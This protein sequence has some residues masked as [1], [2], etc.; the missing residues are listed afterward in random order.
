MYSGKPRKSPVCLKN[1][2]NVLE[3]LFILFTTTMKEQL[4]TLLV[5]DSEKS[6]PDNS[7]ILILTRFWSGFF[8]DHM[9][10]SWFLEGDL[11][12]SDHV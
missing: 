8:L 2:K 3:R 12:V 5:C 10:Q 6:F 9:A 11:C 7:D 1:P 4:W